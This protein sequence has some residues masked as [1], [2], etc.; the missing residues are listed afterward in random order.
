LAK[1]PPETSKFR[2]RHLH[3]GNAKFKSR[4][5]K[6]NEMT[7]AIELNLFGSLQNKVSPDVK[8]PIFHKSKTALPL[9]VLFERYRIPDDEVQIVMVN[10]RAVLK[11]ILV[12]PGDRVSLFSKEYP[13]FVDWNGFRSSPPPM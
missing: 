7:A 13:F 8:L 6:G 12:Q 3:S 10:H 11:D 1:K 4:I 9:P 2:V 5:N